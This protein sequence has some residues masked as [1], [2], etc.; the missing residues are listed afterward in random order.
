MTDEI[1]QADGL[2]A[3]VRDGIARAI[4]AIGL[5]GI[6]LI[7]TLDAPTHFV[8][9]SDTWLGVA[10][11]GLIT[12][13]LILALGLIAFGGTRIWSAAAALIT[14]TAIGFVLSRTTGLPGDTGDVGNWGESLGIA[15]LF[16]EGTFLMLASSVLASRRLGLAAP[17]RRARSAAPA[18]RREQGS[19]RPAYDL[20]RGA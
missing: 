20:P 16:V 11:V 14:A 9:G 12:A 5:A 4:G 10:Y 19:P 15:S 2:Q 6:A 13:A 18:R 1:V 7:H 3:A 8:G 17:P